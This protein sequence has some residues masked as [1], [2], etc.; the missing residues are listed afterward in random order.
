[1]AC[2]LRR[3]GV[4]AEG[5]V[6]LAAERTPDLLVALVGTLRGGGCYVPLDPGYPRERLAW[7]IEDSGCAAVLRVGVAEAALPPAPAGRAVGD[8][9]G[10]VG[11]RR[12]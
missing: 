8:A 3:L 9:G 4:G 6:A 7:M 11:A 1:M 10:G 12:R 5:R 2:G